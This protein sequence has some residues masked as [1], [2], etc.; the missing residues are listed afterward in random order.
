MASFGGTA[1]GDI[2]LVPAPFLKNPKGI[3]DIEEWYVTTLTRPEYVHRIFE[4]Q[5]EIALGNLEKIAARVGDRVQAV[6]LCGT[7]F[8]TQ[9]SQFCSVPT[10]KKLYLP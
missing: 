4:R 9:S 2:A 3:R 5:T 7:D 8:G 1:L 6:F 10:F